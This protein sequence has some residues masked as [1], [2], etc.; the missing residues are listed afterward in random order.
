MRW[1]SKY[2]NHI[3]KLFS[4]CCPNSTEF[5][6]WLKREQDKNIFAL[7]ASLL[8]WGHE[9]KACTAGATKKQR[10]FWTLAKHWELLKGFDSDHDLL[11]SAAQLGLLGRIT[12]YTQLEDLVQAIT[13]VYQFHVLLKNWVTAN[14]CSQNGLIFFIELKTALPDWE[15][16]NY[17]FKIE[18]LFR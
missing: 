7:T 18:V 3:T 6:F 12:K 2:L 13:S 9:P 17:R 8:I 1:S 10:R 15:K 11:W 4:A 16:E 14:H 5:D